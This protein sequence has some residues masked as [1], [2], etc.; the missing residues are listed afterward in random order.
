MTPRHFA[1]ALLLAAGGCNDTSAV[2]VDDRAPK[3]CTVDDECVA[4][5]AYDICRGTGGCPDVAIHRDELAEFER[6]LKG[7]Y[8]KNPGCKSD[9][10]EPAYHG[11]TPNCVATA[12]CIQGLCSLTFDR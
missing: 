3:P 5:D 11:Y 10:G 6:R 8:E 4:V 7:N 2:L 9:F 1:Y 12:E